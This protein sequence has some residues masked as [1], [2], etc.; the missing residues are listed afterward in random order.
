MIAAWVWRFLNHRL[1]PVEGWLPLVLLFA[2]LV[3]LLG[4]V[5]EVGWVPEDGVVVPAAMGGLVLGLLLAKRPLQTLPAWILLILYGLLLNLIWLGRLFPPL[6]VILAGWGE[7]SQFWRQGGALFIDRTGSWFQA[8]FGGGRSAETVVFALGMG[9]LAWL[10]AAYAAWSTYRR[11]QALHGLTIMGFV[12]ALNSYFG[13]VAAY[14]TPLF[15]GLAVLLVALVQYQFLEL[16]WQETAVDYSPEV[17]FDLILHAGAMAL[18]LLMLSAV[19]PTLSSSRLSDWL[20]RQTAVQQMEQTW[21]RVFSGVRAPVGADS[22]IGPGGPGGSGILPRAYLLREAPERLETVVM[23]ARVTTPDG[24]LLPST[25]SS[26]LRWR[27]LSFETYTGRGWALSEER[28]E[29]LPAG[30][31]I[32]LPPLA[33]QAQL[34]QWV[35]WQADDRPLRYTVGFPQQFSGPISVYWRGLADLVRV[36]GGPNPYEATTVVSTASAA[37]LRQARVA[38]VPEALLARYTALPANTPLRVHELAQEIAGSFANPFDQ[39]K[40]LEQFLRQYPY[41]LAVKAPPANIDVV[42]YF[43]FSAQEGYCDYYASA[44]VVMA[45]SLGLPARLVI[46]FVAQPPDE[47]LMQTIRLADGH[48]WPEIYF[49][50]YGWVAFEPTAGLNEAWETAVIPPSSPERN[51]QQSETEQAAP[52]PLPDADKPVPAVWPWL[53]GAGLAIFLLLAG[54]RWQSSRQTRMNEV[55]DIYGRFWRGATQLGAPTK[56]SQTPHEFV[57]QFNACL[58]RLKQPRLARWAAAL[59]EPAS[60]LTA[61]YERWQYGPKPPPEIG[62]DIRPLWLAMRR[63]LWRLRLAQLLRQTNDKT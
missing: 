36:Q 37:L 32:P 34:R 12:L 53:V 21:E 42:E 24:Q 47:Q 25:Q 39:A 35:D 30:A 57:A 15:V 26:F 23:I 29:E 13:G 27:G 45:R 6:T 43:L 1:R 52:L 58:G 61:L 31:L 3:C 62:K 54:W 51:D 22:G 19:L 49:A 20:A 9:L 38:D 60:I 17:R 59:H 63:S 5:L 48:S 44:M 40:A 50:G 16:G 10:L 14:W 33:R 7:L 28:V 11:R 2:L 8:W 4:A 56:P 41:S 46:G 55:E 18:A